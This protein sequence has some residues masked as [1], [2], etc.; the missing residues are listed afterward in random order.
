[1]GRHWVSN[2]DFE[3]PLNLNLCYTTATMNTMRAEWQYRSCVK[4]RIFEFLKGGRRTC[5]SIPHN[6]CKGHYITFVKKLTR[7]S[8][9]LNRYRFCQLVIECTDDGLMHEAKFYLNTSREEQVLSDIDMSNE[10]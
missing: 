5:P 10:E 3:Y 8:M 4:K 7:M 9:R 1:M 2:D 6:C